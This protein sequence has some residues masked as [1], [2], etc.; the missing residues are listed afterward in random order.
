MMNLDDQTRA[1]LR[2]L[3]DRLAWFL[4]RVILTVELVIVICHFL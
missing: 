3:R 2:F 4:I 1:N